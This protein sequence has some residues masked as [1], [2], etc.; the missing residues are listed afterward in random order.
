VPDFFNFRYPQ[1]SFP[2]VYKTRDEMRKNLSGWGTV[3]AEQGK[4]TNLIFVSNDMNKRTAY[5]ASDFIN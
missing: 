5:S 1:T 3:P 4:D 2:P